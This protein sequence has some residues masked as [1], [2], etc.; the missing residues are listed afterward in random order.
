[1]QATILVGADP[2]VR[3]GGDCLDQE[4]GI[5]QDQ[6]LDMLIQHNI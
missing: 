4:A 5:N 1:M 3:P 6:A 2:R